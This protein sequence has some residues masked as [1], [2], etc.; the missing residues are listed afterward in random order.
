MLSPGSDYRTLNNTFA[1][2]I[3]DAFN[4][5]HAVCDRHA[6]GGNRLALI[7][8]ER[9]GKVVEH[10]FDHLQKAANRLANGLQAHGVDRGD[11]I[12]ILLGQQVE[13]LI[14]HLA[15]YKLGAI[16]VPLFG[17]F[18]PE[19]LSF[20]LRDSGARALLT[21]QDGAEKIAPIRTDLSDL[22]LVI[23]TELATADSV[24]L[25][26]LLKQASDRFETVSTLADD[27][28]LIIYTSGTTGPPKGA[29]HAHRVL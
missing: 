22:D 29:L 9:T 24:H 6:D 17:L 2:E 15:I 13:T 26:N 19:A 25:D 20:R 1:W 12:A 16:A 8:V 28:A 23:T 21:D 10:S 4:I 18:G 3:P 7:E 11:R 5:A 14:G 27:P